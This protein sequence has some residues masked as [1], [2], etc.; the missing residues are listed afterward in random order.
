MMTSQQIQDGGQTPSWKSFWLY[1]GAIFQISKEQAEPIHTQRWH[2]QKS[3]FR[4]FK[5][6][7]GRHFENGFENGPYEF[8]TGY[9]YGPVW[10]ITTFTES[11]RSKLGR[12]KLLYALD[13]FLVDTD[14]SVASD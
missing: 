6:A 7:D 8:R 3:K 13:N 2:N 5:M 12:V 9:S 4:K 10:I 1:L 14:T 11:Q